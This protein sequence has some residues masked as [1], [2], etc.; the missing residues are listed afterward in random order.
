MTN[1]HFPVD[2]QGT[3]SLKKQNKTDKT[4]FHVDATTPD[5]KNQNKQT[6]KKKPDTNNQNQP[7]NHS[8]SIE[9]KT[10]TRDDS[11]RVKASRNLDRRQDNRRSE[12]KGVLLNTRSEQDRRKSAGQRE[13]DLD[14]NNK[15]FGI[16][17]EA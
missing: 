7:D 13:Q 4:T 6:A 1:I 15:K 10:L 8:K 9:N 3:Q 2:G 11:A 12:N 17:T 5:S 16:D 14:D